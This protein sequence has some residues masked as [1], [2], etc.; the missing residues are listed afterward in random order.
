MNREGVDLSA[1][2]RECLGELRSTQPERQAEF[3]IQ[4]NVHASADPRLLRLGL[5]NLLRNGEK[6][7][8]GKH[9]TRIEFG[10]MKVEGQV[11]FSV[12]DNGVCFDMRQASH[13]FEPFRRAHSEKAFPGTS[14][15]LSIVQRIIDRHGG[16]IWAKGEK[17][18]GAT[19][20]FTL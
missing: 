15:G 8:A 2:V 10:A 7:T 19:F 18:K 9:V 20:C 11:V 4:D 14:V 17:G 1:L 3:R 12:R 5:E 16:T 13:I 6:F